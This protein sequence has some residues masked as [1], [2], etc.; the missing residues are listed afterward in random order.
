LFSGA[1]N[2]EYG[3]S[4]GAMSV[5]IG[6]L[7]VGWH[8]GEAY[9]G[10]NFGAPQFSIDVQ[11]DGRF[12]VVASRNADY[13]RKI[14]AAEA[15]E[16]ATDIHFRWF[17]PSIRTRRLGG[18]AVLGR[19]YAVDP[20]Q[21]AC[22][23]VLLRALADGSPVMTEQEIVSAAMIE[24][25]NFADVFGLG[26]QG[27]ERAWTGLLSPGEREGTWQLTPPPEGMVDLGQETATLDRLIQLADED[28]RAAEGRHQAG[29][30]STGEL[31]DARLKLA[32]A[33]LRR[34]EQ[35]GDKDLQKRLLEEIVEIQRQQLDVVQ[36]QHERGTVPAT[37]VREAE[38][39]LLQAQARLEG[40]NSGGRSDT[41]QPGD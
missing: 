37:A 9:S 14:A 16:S 38:A 39:A 7:A 5:V 11:R 1:G 27:N 35:R 10:V 4:T 6:D 17:E 23:K 19:P 36:S 30:A 24:G 8:R 3:I 28:L 33:K 2:I 25:R 34:A 40:V 29:V 18:G 22:I 12:H 13:F 26:L 21:A 32:E 41:D 31:Q 15:P 20:D